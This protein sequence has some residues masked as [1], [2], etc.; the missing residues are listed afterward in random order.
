LASHLAE[1][2]EVHLGAAWYERGMVRIKFLG[3]VCAGQTIRV[4]G[5]VRGETGAVEI[6][7]WIDDEAGAGVAVANCALRE[8]AKRSYR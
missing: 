1:A 4:E 7:A 6:D 5:V 8:P 2:L 3:A